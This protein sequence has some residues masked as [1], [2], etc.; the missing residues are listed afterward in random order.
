MNAQNVIPP[1]FAPDNPHALDLPIADVVEVAGDIEAR[2]MVAGLME[3][4]DGS[5]LVREDGEPSQVWHW[6]SHGS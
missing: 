5:R 4:D 2:E 1:T 6:V 3:L